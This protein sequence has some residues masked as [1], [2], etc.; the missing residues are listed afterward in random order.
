MSGLVP[1]YLKKYYADDPFFQ[2]AKVVVSL[3]DNGF[4]G[5]L[6]KGLVDK[7]AFDDVHEDIKDYL[8]NPTHLGMIQSSLQYADAVAKG[9]EVIP[10]D[11]QNYINEHKISLLEYCTKDQAKEVYNNFY[12]EEVINSN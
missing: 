10:Q 12:I 9:E 11:V 6:D 7:L 2:E 8:V 1:A 5:E 3:F 4:E